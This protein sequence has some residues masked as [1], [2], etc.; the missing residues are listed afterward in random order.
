MPRQASNNKELCR[1]STGTNCRFPNSSGQ[2]SSPTRG[3]R[4]RCVGQNFC[5][6][7]RRT[8][9]S[10][11]VNWG[12]VLGGQV[13]RRSHQ[14]TAPSIRI[15]QC[16]SEQVLN[17]ILLGRLGTPCLQKQVP[18]ASWPPPHLHDIP[19]WSAVLAVHN[20]S[21]SSKGVSRCVCARLCTF[22][23]RSLNQKVRRSSAHPPPPPPR[24]PAEKKANLEQNPSRPMSFLF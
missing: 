12:E 5:A 4:W 6:K 24:E 3:P 11:C 20:L 10:L 15:A 23:E 16:P 19:P 21:G 2:L 22:K 17:S 1:P 8:A 9:S 14:L 7:L 18:D 13:K